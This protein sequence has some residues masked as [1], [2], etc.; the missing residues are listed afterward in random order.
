MAATIYERCTDDVKE[1]ADELIK[2]YHSDLLTKGKPVEIEY[3]FAQLEPDSN[4][5]RP[6][7]NP[8]KLHGVACYAVVKVIPA[9][10]RALGSKDAEII[11]D[12]D[13]WEK[14]TMGQR[15]A[16]LD[17]ELEHLMTKRD[18]AGVMVLDAYER[19]RLRMKHH[20]WDLGWFDSIAQRHAHFSVEV[21][22]A[23]KLANAVGKLYFQQDLPFFE[24][25][26]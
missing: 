22:Q 18:A 13:K 6:T 9:K 26:A 21:T 15:R 17:H 7:G 20:D 11:I 3:V 19:P 4:G 24:E 5:D 12:K 14:M 1:V 8:V 16:L 23:R 10:H 25:A 2:K